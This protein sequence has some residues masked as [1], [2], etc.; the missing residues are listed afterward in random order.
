MKSQM[1]FV[2]LTL[3]I[4]EGSN[5][6]ILFIPI[7]QHPPLHL[8]LSKLIINTRNYLNWSGSILNKSI[9]KFS[10]LLIIM[11]LHYTV[12]VWKGLCISFISM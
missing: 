7:S 8:G 4:L 3:S 5:E 2:K 1:Y 11:F 9:W 6:N 10:C 12:R